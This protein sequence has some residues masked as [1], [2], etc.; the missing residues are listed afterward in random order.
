M[1][2]INIK[3]VIIVRNKDDNTKFVAQLS[4]EFAQAV[5]IYC[6]TIEINPEQFIRDAIVE[7]LIHSYVDIKSE[8]F[9][10]VGTKFP[11]AKKPLKNCLKAMKLAIKIVE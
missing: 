9:I 7:K 1:R 8:D 11:E 3:K 10:Y 2:C 5:N 6:E 4:K